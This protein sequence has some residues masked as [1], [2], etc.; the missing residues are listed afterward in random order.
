MNNT[1]PMKDDLRLRIEV[2]GREAHL[3]KMLRKYKFGEFI[4]VKVSNIL[5]RVQSKESNLIEEDG[6]LDLI[7]QKT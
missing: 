6:G 3:I 7:H 4:I 2:S 1:S 5:V